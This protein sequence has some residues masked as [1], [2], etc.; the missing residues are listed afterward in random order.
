M[1]TPVVD[2]TEGWL[3]YIFDNVISDAQMSG[4]FE[5]V[6]GHEPK[7]APITGMTAAIWADSIDPL[8]GASGLAWTAGRIVFICRIYQNM[9]SEPQDSIDPRVMKAV[10]N[11][12]RRY[13]GDFDFN[14]SIRN[15][16]VLGAFGSALR[17][18]AGYVE[19]DTKLFRIVDITIPCVIDAIW[20]QVQ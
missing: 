10:S 1:T 11:L 3:D 15:V 9:L 5:K 7:Q 8:P 19:I 2:P 16:D 12:M 13:Q 14:G 4:Y 6:N 18:Q 20:S 17:A